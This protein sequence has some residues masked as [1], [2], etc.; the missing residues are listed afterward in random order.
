MDGRAGVH[1][2]GPNEALNF[3]S[4]PWSPY[5]GNAPNQTANQAI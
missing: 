3:E 1:D 2:Q 4:G 5:P